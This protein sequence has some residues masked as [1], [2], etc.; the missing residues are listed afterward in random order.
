MTIQ[1]YMIIRLFGDVYST[2]FILQGQG[3][4]AQHGVIEYNPVTRSY[5]IKD[6][7]S[8]LGTQLNGYPIFGS[9]ELKEGDQLAFGYS[10][11]Y[12]FETPTVAL[13][14][15][16]TQKA[17]NGNTPRLPNLNEVHKILLYIIDEYSIIETRFQNQRRPP[18]PAK[19]IPFERPENVAILQNRNR[20]WAEY[21]ERSQNRGGSL[22]RMRTRRKGIILKVF[23]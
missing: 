10:K 22:D 7:G 18:S 12:L 14:T 23:K 15:R 19:L 2:M 1:L 11:T 5:W 21:R 6:L 17:R 4:D 16:M 13:S 3:V 9:H 20:K 8:Q